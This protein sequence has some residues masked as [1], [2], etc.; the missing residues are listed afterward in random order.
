MIIGG[1]ARFSEKF[2][3]FIEV[4]VFKFVYEPTF[5]C[6]GATGLIWM[7]PGYA[8]LFYLIN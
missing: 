4:I 7:M 1:G 2:I 3:E 6:G 8:D 5:S